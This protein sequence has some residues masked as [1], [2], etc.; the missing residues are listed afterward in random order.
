MPTRPVVDGV[1]S[2][3]RGPALQPHDLC[4]ELR[5]VQKLALLAVD[6]RQQLSV[7]IALAPLGER[8]VDAMLAEALLEPT[9]GLADLL[10]TKWSGASGAS[11]SRPCSPT[12][13]H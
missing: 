7:E 3:S 11:S 4:D 12:E 6:G 9:S 8:V 10:I 1:A 2:T 5:M 13:H